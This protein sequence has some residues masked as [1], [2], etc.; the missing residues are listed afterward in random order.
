MLA[1]LYLIVYFQHPDDKNV[2]YFPKVVVILGFALAAVSVLML[3]LDVANLTT[4]GGFPMETMWIVVYIVIAVFAIV[5][6][7][8]A[9]FFYESEEADG[10][11]N[12]FTGAIKG[13]F[14]ILFLFVAIVVILWFL[15]GI[16]DIPTIV[17]TN[18]LTTTTPAYFTSESARK[19]SQEF[20]E[21]EPFEAAYWSPLSWTNMR[22]EYRSLTEFLSF[23]VS[24][25]LF[26]ITIV[27][28]FGWFLFVIFGGIGIAALPMDMIGDF[29]NRPQ[30]IPYDKYLERKT[31]IGDRATE[32]V[33]IGKEIQSK[34]SGGIMGRKDRRNY[35]RFRAAVFLLEEDYEILKISYQRQGGKVIFYYAQFF[36]GFIAA[37]LS[38]TWLMQNIL[39]MWT[40]PEPFFPFLNLLLISLDNAWGFLGTIT[41]GI[42]SFYLLFC[43]LKGNF[44]FGLRLFFLFPIHPMK[45]GGTM[46]N[47]FLFNVGLILICCVSIT[48]FATMGFSGYANATAIN[49]MFN[50]AVRNIRVLKWFWVIY[51]IAFFCMAVLTAIFLLVKPKD[52]P[53]KIK[54]SKPCPPDHG[55]R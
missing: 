2:A 26:I 14:A 33:A 13:T 11:G 27:S 9:M 37:A 32:L 51:I 4:N 45:V 21:G 39:F 47:A 18:S 16:A 44:K 10:S 50:T 12:Q 15:I 34:L 38:L 42:Y 1:S 25:P 3:P 36:L 49:T 41:Y 30:R 43:V 22:K 40:Q 24:I 28:F 53:K 23:R 7:P 55:L 19:W 35:N 46:M 52:K 29:K 6:V 20:P 54:L 31:K 8:F 48:Q 5:I 17:V